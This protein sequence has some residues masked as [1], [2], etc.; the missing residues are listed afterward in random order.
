VWRRGGGGDKV[1][2]VGGVAVGV[3]GGGR[4]I[5]GLVGEGGVSGGWVERAG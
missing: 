2:V 4:G 5:G 1:G 3:A